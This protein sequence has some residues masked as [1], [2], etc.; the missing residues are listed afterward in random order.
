MWRARVPQ[1]SLL[2][3]LSGR[4]NQ[5]DLPQLWRYVVEDY[6]EA[7]VTGSSSWPE[8]AAPSS[9]GN[10]DEE[11]PAPQTWWRESAEVT[12]DG[13]PRSS[14]NLEALGPVT[15]ERRHVRRLLACAVCAGID[16]ETEREYN[17][18]IT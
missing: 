3:P 11:E 8:C 18:E 12:A 10:E 4:G 14:V 15:A 7:L 13:V 6:T 1:A 2:P 9:L 17:N 5:A 16:W